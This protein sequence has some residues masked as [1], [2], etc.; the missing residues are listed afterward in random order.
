MVLSAW[1]L[2]QERDP[3]PYTKFRVLDSETINE[4]SVETTTHLESMIR[5]ALFEPGYL[6]HI[7]E[8]LGW[9]RTK[10]A[11][12]DPRTSTPPRVKRGD[13]GEALFG[14]VLEEQHG[15]EIPVPKLRYKVTASQ[16]LTGT[17]ILALKIDESRVIS[18]VCFVETKLRTNRDNAVAVEGCRQLAD[19]YSEKVPGIL[20]FISQRLFERNDSRLEPFLAYLRSRDDL[21]NIDTFRLAV[22][23]DYNSWR[24]TA[25]E[26]LEDSDVAVS[27]LRVHAVRIQDLSALIDTA[28]TAIGIVGIEDGD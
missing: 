24:E 20:S 17:D 27:P 16:T 2:E 25:L 12:L 15:Y 1:L 5:D 21:T 6:S 3:N 10:V 23:W 7:A 8:L 18:E 28:Y 26:N 11:I 22:F 19:D 4:P 13:F 9:E 14:A